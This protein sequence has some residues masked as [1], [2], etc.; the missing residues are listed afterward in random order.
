M[1]APAR[2][3]APAA[4]KSLR[5]AYGEALRDCLEGG[6]ES[7]FGRAYALGR[8][9]LDSHYG[10]VDVAL[11]HHAALT[12]VLEPTLAPALRAQRLAAAGDFF[13]E[14]LS[15]FEMAHR[16]FLEAN[17]AQRGVNDTLERE[18]KRVARLLHDSLGQLLF[19][20]QLAYNDLERDMPAHLAAR[21]SEMQQLMQQLDDQLHW[22]SYELYPVILEDLGLAPA[23]QELVGHLSKRTDL[24]ITF[25]S[26][27]HQRL[28][29]EIET[30]VYRAAHEALL[31]SIKHARPSR[32][33]VDLHL[34]SGVLRCTV[35]DDGM[36][37]ARSANT[38][39][40][41]PGFGMLGIRERLKF[42]KG[43]VDV[44]SAPGT[45]TEIRLTVPVSEH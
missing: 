18:A 30:C 21:F 15:P 9:A 28:P 22:T 33:A 42:V 8:T 13:A 2:S 31:N 12:A 43:T 39:R 41:R 4:L 24:P 1:P 25:E 14:F 35:V 34:A 40:S 32:V 17:D 23:L 16:A 11:V 44:S 37:I 19:A 26:S 27:L 29:Y 3:E 5:E 36:G 45:G 10:V 6:G 20:L 38:P 7:A